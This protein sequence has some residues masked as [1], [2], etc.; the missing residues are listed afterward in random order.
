LQAL[1]RQ[2]GAP[3]FERRLSTSLQ[4]KM[5]HGFERIQRIAPIHRT[6]SAQRCCG[7]PTAR[8]A[9]AKPQV[10]HCKLDHR[11]DCFRNMMQNAAFAL[12]RS[13]W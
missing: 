11:Y 13:G 10:C 9:R 3:R 12:T 5:E 2:T 8:Q 6:A 1:Y 7:A 4:R